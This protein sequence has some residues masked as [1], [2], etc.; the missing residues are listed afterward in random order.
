MFGLLI[1]GCAITT[2]YPVDRLQEKDKEMTCIDIQR[3]YNSNTKKASD[4]ISANQTADVGGF[5]FAI[6]IFPVWDTG[7]ADGHE[8]DALLDRNEYLM[9]LA[10]DL[11]CDASG[12]LEQPSR[13]KYRAKSTD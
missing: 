11:N 7:N 5:L 13:Y 10:D 9:Y 3:E 4:K 2:P 8:G 1:S 12:Y 6:L